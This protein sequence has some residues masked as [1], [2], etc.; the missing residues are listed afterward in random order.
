MP[1]HETEIL[2]NT[3]ATLAQARCPFFL[4]KFCNFTFRVEILNLFKHNKAG[5]LTISVVILFLSIRILLIR[6]FPY[7]P[8][9]LEDF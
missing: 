9:I 3:R 2:R 4:R 8:I 1:N 5:L 7:I 6:V